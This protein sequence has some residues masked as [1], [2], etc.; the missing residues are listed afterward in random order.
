MPQLF[1]LLVLQ[2]PEAAELGRAGEV[3]EGE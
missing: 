3:N 2:H 1:D